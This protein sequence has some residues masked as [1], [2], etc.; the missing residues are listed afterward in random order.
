ML[1]TAAV[2]AVSPTLLGCPAPVQTATPAPTPTPAL[3]PSADIC[4]IA[5]NSALCQVLSP[6]TASEPTRPVQT[7]TNE[8]IKTV[9]SVVPPSGG[10]SSP[11]EPNVNS[12]AP[13]SPPSTNDK[14]ADKKDDKKD[15]ATKVASASDPGKSQQPSKK[16]YCN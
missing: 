2:C 14:T 6:P 7:A 1:P 10:P 15:D 11:T 3:P 8:I 12:T 4:T 9:T 16:M 5:P 13:A